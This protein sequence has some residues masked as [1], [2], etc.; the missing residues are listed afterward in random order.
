MLRLLIDKLCLTIA[1]ISA[2][3]VWY[4]LPRHRGTTGVATAFVAP[5]RYQVIAAVAGSPAQRAGIR[6]GDVLAL[7]KALARI[8][9]RVVGDRYCLQAAALRRELDTLR[10][11]APV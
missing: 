2:A 4:I 7:D 11:A 3:K 6:I 5:H 1:S 9:E 8:A 10:L